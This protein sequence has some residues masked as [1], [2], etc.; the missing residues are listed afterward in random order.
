MGDGC[1]QLNGAKIII[2]MSTPTHQKKL[3]TVSN[4]PQKSLLNV[5][6]TKKSRPLFKFSTPQNLAIILPSLEI[7]YSPPGFLLI[8][9]RIVFTKRR[10]QRYRLFKGWTERFTV[11]PPFSC[12]L[13]VVENK[14]GFK[15]SV[16]AS[17]VEDIWGKWWFFSPETLDVPLGE[18][19]AGNTTYCFQW[20]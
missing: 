17:S 20:R 12:V 7:Q 15:S 1:G 10:T 2:R 16:S 11:F 4:I 14:L 9:T 18:T 3:G 8:W 19:K 6:R 5:T 13:T